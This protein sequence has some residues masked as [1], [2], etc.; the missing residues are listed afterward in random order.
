[1]DEQLA[2]TQTRAV[3]GDFNIK[4]LNI[5]KSELTQDQPIEA[6]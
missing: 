3:M 4:T 2:K 6:H 1:M 5:F